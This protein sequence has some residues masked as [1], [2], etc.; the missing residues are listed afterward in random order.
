MDKWH[1]LLFIV[2]NKQAIPFSMITNR[3]KI[4]QLFILASYFY[5]VTAD[6]KA[7]VLDCQI[8]NISHTLVANRVVDH[9]NVDH[10]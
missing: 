7:A 5:H 1:L 8:S 9:S 3:F 2:H 10:S 4:T 6:A